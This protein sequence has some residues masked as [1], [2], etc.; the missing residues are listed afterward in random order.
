MVQSSTLSSTGVATGEV[1]GFCAEFELV[2]GDAVPL[3]S[4]NVSNVLFDAL[5]AIER[6]MLVE[7]GWTI[8]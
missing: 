8:E 4:V 2:E 3:G 5:E 7:I 1:R 6:G